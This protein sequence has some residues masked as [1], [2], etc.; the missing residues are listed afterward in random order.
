MKYK[1]LKVFLVLAIL[2]LAL[3]LLDDLA[4]AGSPIASIGYPQIK[5]NG[6]GSITPTDAP[7]T[8]SGNIYTL[9]DNLLEQT[10]V[11]SRNDIVLEGA[12]H[13]I[14]TPKKAGAGLTIYNRIGVQVSPDEYPD[15][16]V[17]RKNITIRNL[18]VL[19][20]I[21]I[22]CGDYCK[23]ENVRAENI[24][25]EGSFNTIIN[26]SC[27]VGL[28][29]NT[30][31]NLITKNNITSL[32]ISY[33]CYSSKFYLNNFCLSEYPA[34]LSTISWDNGSM[35]NFWSNYTIKYPNAV[36]LGNSGIGNTQ[37]TIEKEHY[38]SQLERQYGGLFNV[39]FMSLDY[40]PI[41]DRFPLMY[42][43]DLEND[44][45]ALSI[46]TATST[47]SPTQLPTNNTGP[48]PPRTEPFLTTLAIVIVVL[49]AV[50]G[51]SLLV[52]FKK[53]KKDET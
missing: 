21:E 50:A 53:R 40:V 46:P 19:G 9:T 20:N 16:V 31:N 43:Y 49:V 24:H 36:E 32:F 23:I 27:G 41:V 8:R 44:K 15:G 26:S 14:D 2:P 51:V 33:G 22:Y 3:P 34:V 17:Y 38:A 10:I 4:Y 11:I 35:G 13:C 47:P 52:Y 30:G 1:S 37:Y 12:G 42:P 7:I 18:T 5:I 45:I 6:D 48:E 39:T 25:I 28:S 29:T